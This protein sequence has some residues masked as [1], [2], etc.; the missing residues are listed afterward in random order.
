MQSPG[1]SLPSLQRRGAYRQGRI[2]LGR[3][4]HPCSRQLNV[5]IGIVV[6]I[7]GRKPE[8][9]FLNQFLI[10]GPLLALGQ[11]PLVEEFLNGLR[12]PCRIVALRVGIYFAS[13][14]EKV[15]RI[16]PIMQLS[17]RLLLQLMPEV[18]KQLP[19]VRVGHGKGFLVALAL[20]ALFPRSRTP[21]LF[22]I[23]ALNGAL[24]G[25]LN[26]GV[27]HPAASFHWRSQGGKSTVAGDETVWNTAT[28]AVIHAQA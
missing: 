19:V 20:T 22:P 6:I 25:A 14:F 26:A 28:G 9:P 2:Q 13:R 24:N 21:T 27:T 5:Q 4:R 23:H 12:A 7:V 16:R 17:F 15:L 18:G 1:W 8:I 11:Q 10:V 3:R